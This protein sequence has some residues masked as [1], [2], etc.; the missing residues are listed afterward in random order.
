MNRSISS[1]AN[2]V[3][4]LT[5]LDADHGDEPLSAGETARIVQAKGIPGIE[6]LYGKYRR[7]SFARHF[8]TVTAF[9]IVET[10]VMRTCV[11]GATHRAP[12]G[13]VILFNPGDVHA[14]QPGDGSGWSFRMFY[15]EHSLLQEFA[16]RSGQ[17]RPLWFVQALAENRELHSE[18]L[19]LHRMLGHDSDPL[20]AESRLVSVLEQIAGY[21]QWTTRPE[22]ADIGRSKIERVREYLHACNADAVTLRTLSDVADLSPWHLLRSFRAQ[23]GITPHAYHMQTRVEQSRMLLASGVSIAETALQTGFADQSHFTRQFKR[24]TGVTPGRYLLAGSI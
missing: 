5:A 10:G 7:F 12:A 18:L 21:S 17:N 16:N 4:A 19:L 11:Q 20:A 1:P 6:L 13:N 9:G 22:S 24:F 15:L 8:H 23:V 14:P 2:I 3:P